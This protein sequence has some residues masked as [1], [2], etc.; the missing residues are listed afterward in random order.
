MSRLG[1]RGAARGSPVSSGEPVGH[2]RARQPL[3]VSA[4]TAKSAAGEARARLVG[5]AWLRGRGS[6]TLSLLQPVE[7][8]TACWRRY[9]TNPQPRH[10]APVARQRVS[11]EGAQARLHTNSSAASLP[12]KARGAGRSR[13]A[14]NAL[15]VMTA[16]AAGRVV[17]IYTDGACRGNPGPGG[18]ASTLSFGARQ[19]DLAGTRA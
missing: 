4:G 3:R 1:G 19:Q 6:E 11:V 18:W 16:A 2:A 17:E 9:R 5:F 15:A 14:N 10:Y 12:R 7:L 13:Q 8:G